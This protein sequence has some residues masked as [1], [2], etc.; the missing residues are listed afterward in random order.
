MGY[1]ACLMM[2]CTILHSPK[3]QAVFLRVSY[4]DPLE[5]SLN[6]EAFV[7]DLAR[8]E[9]FTTTLPGPTSGRANRLLVK[10]ADMPNIITCW[11]GFS[12]HVLDDK[13]R[14]ITQ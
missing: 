12:L 14:D 3:K 7:A 13:D 9:G 6:G 2:A 4:D 5:L 10:I 8:R 11:A 1:Y